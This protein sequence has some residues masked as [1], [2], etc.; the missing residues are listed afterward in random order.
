MSTTL[1]AARSANNTLWS[2]VDR[3]RRGLAINSIVDLSRPAQV[4]PYVVVDEPL[5]DLDIL[6]DLLQCSCSIFSGYYLQA[7]TVLSNN[8]NVRTLRVI[9][10]LNPSRTSVSTAIGNYG[11]TYFESFDDELNEVPS[12]EDNS[13]II[14]E[15]ES[16]AVGKLLELDIDVPSQSNEKGVEVVK[17][18]KFK[19]PVMVS[20]RPAFVD[21]TTLTHIFSSS[22]NKPSA[23]DRWNLVKAKQIAFFRDMVMMRDIIDAH[24]RTLAKDSSGVYESIND[25]RR[26]NS[27]MAIT[28]NSTS[29]GDAS[30]IVMITRETERALS[31]E[32]KGQLSNPRVRARLFD[33][34]YL[35]LLF[36]VDEDFEQVTIYHRGQD[37]PQRVRFADIKRSEKGKGPDIT[38]IL[39]SFVQQNAPTF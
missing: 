33:D 30:N 34:T 6:T 27:L 17:A 12:F 39:A 14:Y 36:V 38:G 1:S 28:T 24:R 26:N 3:L 7:F 16:L 15:N 10:Q 23:D 8:A 18:N 19:I 25:R 20:I 29:F 2:V 11:K 32:L 31:R 13:K 9:D 37:T 35:I 22:K 4:N 21:S 5:R